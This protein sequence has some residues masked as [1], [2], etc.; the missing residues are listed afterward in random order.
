MLLPYN[1]LLQ[2]TAREA[3]G[4]DLTGQVVIIDEAHSTDSLFL[5][6]ASDLLIHLFTDLTSTLLSLSTARLP[7]RTLVN[8]RHQL[9]IYLSRFRNR[10]STM[11]AL[12]LKRLM[13]LLDALVQHAEE[14][15][16][17]Q[18]KVDKGN[19][20]AGK[21]RAPEVEVMTSAELLQRLGRKAEGVN[22]LEVEKYLRES[23]VRVRASCILP[24]A[25]CRL[26]CNRSDCTKDIRVLGQD[27]REG[28]RSR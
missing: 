20:T 18:L 12:H 23:K 22:L 28:G 16:D 19:G 27:A 4:I 13:N 10:L 9:S 6:Y 14:W 17:A 21:A 1:L 5:L 15:R 26:A 11:H 2:R 3:L 24:S 25:Y 7:L 8:A